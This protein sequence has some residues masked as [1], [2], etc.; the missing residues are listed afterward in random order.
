MIGLCNQQLPDIAS[1]ESDRSRSEKQTSREERKF[2]LGTRMKANNLMLN[3]MDHDRS[4]KRTL[5][6]SSL[7]RRGHE[8][9][10]PLFFF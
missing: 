9:R 6:I 4:R 7:W 5:E 10:Y 3:D 1:Q 8:W 2:L